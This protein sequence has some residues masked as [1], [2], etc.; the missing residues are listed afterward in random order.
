MTTTTNE[1]LSNLMAAAVPAA[2]LALEGRT[3]EAVALLVAEGA[4]E[5]FASDFLAGY[6]AALAAKT[7]QQARDAAAIERAARIE[8][9]IQILIFEGWDPQAAQSRANAW[10]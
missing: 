3:A 8:Y 5:T 6:V 4:T 7:A 2:D 9:N 1:T 10:G